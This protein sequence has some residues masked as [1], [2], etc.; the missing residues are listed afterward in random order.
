MGIA[1]IRRDYTAGQLDRQALDADPLKQFSQW[2]DEASRAKQAGGRLRRFAIGI[3]KSFAAL[4]GG[5][6]VEANAMSLATV[7]ADGKPSVRTVLLKG[8]DARG[9][10]FYTNYDSR[11][12]RELAANAHAA[13][14]F[15]WPE[16]ERQV[17]ISGIV[18]KL[19]REESERYF[20]S[21]PK[22]SQIA[23]VAS[24]Q[25]SAVPDRASLEKTFHDLA[26]K[27]SSTA[28]PM[29]ENWGGYA[30]SPERIEFWQG[31]A[32]RLHDRFCYSRTAD[33]SW[34]MQRLAP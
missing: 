6:N 17:C 13:L 7:A 22:G 23:A 16:L 10:V 20:H 28:I 32:S 18:S 31:R 4:F 29:P 21:R 34:E 3:Y 33:G 11:K 25:S 8:I 30:L 19:P 14:V 26:S 15:Y 1:D 27:F 9:F 12:G 2:F 24:P 5:M